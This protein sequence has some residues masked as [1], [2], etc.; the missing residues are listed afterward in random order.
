[1]TT[2]LAPRHPPPRISPLFAEVPK[3]RECRPDGPCYPWR[4]EKT[5]AGYFRAWHKRRRTTAHRLAYELVIGPIPDG[6][7]IDHLCRNRECVNP[8][9]LEPV[10]HRENCIRAAR[11]KTQCPRGHEYAGDNLRLYRGRRFCR[12][13]SRER[14]R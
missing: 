7:E 11:L 2:A 10:T 9:H 3:L 13:C 5:D 1:M 12:Q 6:H 4:G 14:V 8:F